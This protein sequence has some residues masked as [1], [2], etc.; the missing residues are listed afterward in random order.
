MTPYP[1]FNFDKYL[2]FEEVLTLGSA[3]Q[4]NGLYQVSLKLTAGS[5]ERDF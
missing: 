3:L 1:I 5:E 2:Q 4:E